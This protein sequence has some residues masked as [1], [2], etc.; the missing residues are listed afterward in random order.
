MAVYK[1]KDGHWRV[2]I[3]YKSA[4]G[5][6]CR[7]YESTKTRKEAIKR[8][9]EL[10]NKLSGLPD[11]DIMF[12][13]LT[14]RFLSSCKESKK[15]STITHYRKIAK[16]HILPFFGSMK[17]SKITTPNIIAWKERI[18]N[19]PKNYSLDY[20]NHCFKVLKLIFKYA[21]TNMN[22]IN[23]AIKR[24]TNFKRDPNAI[25][26]E[27][28]LNYWLPKEFKKW[29]DTI[30]TEI[31]KL[32][33]QSKEYMLYSATRVLVN[34]AYFAGLRKGEANALLVSDFIDVP[35]HTYLRINKSVTQQLGI[36]KYLVTNPKTRNSIR[37]VP[38]SERL[39]TLLR[40]HIKENL[41]QLK[42]QGVKDPY[43][44][45]GVA[46][47]SNTTACS[48]KNRIEEIAG[49]RHVKIHDLRHSFAS[50]LINTGVPINIIA[51]LCGHSSPE[52]TF[53]IYSHLFP[54]TGE[55]VIQGLEKYYQSNAESPNE[56]PENL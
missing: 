17:F 47:L 30:A 43:L 3:K 48:I 29:D 10:I 23:I 50:N 36:G 41:M 16:A 56:N 2:V 51:K 18:N 44:T 22:L 15:L 32:K 42:K 45:F 54:N 14:E 13:E 5:E 31:L 46:P 9:A 20:K 26:K 11:K 34:I 7:Y 12:S 8:E 33:K 1:R 37:N 6:N 40:K 19:N 53:K 35:N 52:I 4:S 25:V 24:T 38:V 27:R 49:I 55:E 39:A 21:E 28:D